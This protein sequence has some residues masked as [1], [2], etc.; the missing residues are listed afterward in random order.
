MFETIK[1]PKVNKF[2]IVSQDWSGLGFAKRLQDEGFE[3]LCASQPK[4]NEDR[5]DEFELVGEGMI[6]KIPFQELWKDRNK[7]RDY[8]WLWDG[9]FDP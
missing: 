2:V 1:P 6:N 9:N 3:I 5:L 7:Y 4:E 8:I